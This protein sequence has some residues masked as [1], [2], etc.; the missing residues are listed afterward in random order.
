MVIVLC[1]LSFVFELASGGGRQA[2]RGRP[3]MSI[4]KWV[5]KRAIKMALV[6][7]FPEVS[8]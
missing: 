5:E 2:R 6:V 3:R 8:G 7:I 1:Q 4:E